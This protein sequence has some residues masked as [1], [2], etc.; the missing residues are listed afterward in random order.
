MV[1]RCVLL[2]AAL[3]HLG[4]GQDPPQAQ[5]PDIPSLLRAGDASY[6]KGDYDTAQEAFLQAWDLA[7]A[8]P[9]EDPARY[10]VLKKLTAIR[11]AAGQFE[12][13]NKYLQMAIDWTTATKGKD[14]PG[15]TDDLLESVSLLRGLKDYGHALTVMTDVLGRHVKASGFQSVAVADDFS[16]F[17]QIQME[18]QKPEDALGSLRSALSIRT[19]LS[20]PL[21]PSLIYDLD[22]MGTVTIALRQYDKAEEAYRHALVIRESMY[23]KDHADLI[24]TVDGL[25]YACFGQKKY[26]EAEPIYQRLLA[27]WIKSVGPEHPVVAM[28]LDKVAVF[29]ADQKKYD[30][31]ED[32]FTRANAIRTHFL[33]SGLTEQATQEVAEGNKPDALALYQRALKVMDPPDPLYETMRSDTENIVKAMAPPAIKLQKKAPAPPTAKKQ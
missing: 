19:Q 1:K 29:Y 2:L 20:G 17:A 24:A 28:T 15:I 9:P 25:A 4:M 16:R 32:A 13:A 14:D 22:R 30:Q 33:A 5:P 27:L 11:S 12:D 10:T 21:D 23:G 8:A 6:L 18:Y 7:Q 3:C 26:D 31:A